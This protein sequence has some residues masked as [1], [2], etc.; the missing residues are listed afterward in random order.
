MRSRLASA[1]PRSSAASVLSAASRAVREPPSS[2]AQSDAAAANAAAA[3]ASC[4]VPI[5]QPARSRA[6]NSP[7]SR[8][9]AA[10]STARSRRSAGEPTSA[11][12]NEASLERYWPTS[13]T[14]SFDS[15]R[16]RSVKVIGTSSARSSEPPRESSSSRIL[17]PAGA[18]PRPSSARRGT[19]KKPDIGSLTAEIGQASDDAMREAMR[20]C[21][22]QPRIPPPRV[23][24]LPTAMS[25]FPSSTAR[26]SAGIAETGCERS[27]SITTTTSA[28][29]SRAPRI[30]A[31]ARPRAPRRTTTRAG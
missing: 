3:P 18:S 19:A 17:K 8:T 14:P 31:P 30:T 1:P 20:R 24:R 25:A 5:A 15:P 28:T 6:A 23:W 21:S 16:T 22:G 12:A 13:V 4:A 29:A 27:A 26:A 2:P 11:P 9:E 7:R 10:A